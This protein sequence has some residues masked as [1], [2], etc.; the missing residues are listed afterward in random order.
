MVIFAEMK[1]LFQMPT[2]AGNLA[3]I[4]ITAIPGVVR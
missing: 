1:E 4:L 3:G 2:R